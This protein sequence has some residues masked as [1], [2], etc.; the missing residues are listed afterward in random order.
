[1]SVL[2]AGIM[3]DCPL[4]CA[5]TAVGT[6]GSDD[7]DEHMCML[8]GMCFASAAGMPCHAGRVHG[9][10]V[11]T[12]AKPFIAGSSCPACG[13]DLRIR[14]RVVEHLRQGPGWPATAG[15]QSSLVS[16]RGSNRHSWLLVMEPT[17]CFVEP[18]GL[19]VSA[20]WLPKVSPAELCRPLEGGSLHVLPVFLVAPRPSSAAPYKGG[21]RA[22]F[23]SF[24]LC[25]VVV[26]CPFQ[27]RC[28]HLE[29][30][31][32]VRR[33]PLESGCL[34]VLCVV[35]VAS[36][37]SSAAPHKGGAGAACV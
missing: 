37:L 4:L 36:R 23:V 3:A 29:A 34:Y 31:L 21:A 13:V 25:L 18:V 35:L 6:P 20:V 17:G 32:A 12:A 33:R 8:C 28:P 19:L 26:C 30:L 16:S 27:R 14:I 7:D 9:L 15:G 1:M 10:G 11:A 2:A 24:G 22:A 5:G